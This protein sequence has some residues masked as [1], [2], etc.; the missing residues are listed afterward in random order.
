MRLTRRSSVRPLLP[1][2]L[3]FLAITCSDSKNPVEPSAPGSPGVTQFAPRSSASATLVGAGDIANCATT[4]SEET[5]R[6]LDA[7]PG[8]VF[9]V[10][11]NAYMHGSDQQFRECYQPT[12]GRHRNRTRPSPGN[13]DYMTAGGTPYFNYFGAEAGPHGLG[14]Y[15]YRLGDWQVFS[16]NS[17]VPADEGS[18][19]YQ[20][21]AAELSG[22][23]S[24]CSLA[25]WHHPVINDGAHG[26]SRQMRAIWKLLFDRGTDVVIAGHDHNYQRHPAYDGNLQRD[27]FRGIRSFIV[28]T[29]GAEEYEFPGVNARAEVRG[30]GWGVLKLT[31]YADSYDWEFVPVP[32]VTLRDF[33]HDTCH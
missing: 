6:L 31:L 11:D 24:R 4:G 32:G 20:W 33:G 8:T 27:A 1:A 28:G 5:A 19:Q 9:T 25:Y 21:L 29:G 13:H 18:A 7:I 2:M 10:G 17:N 3:A 14:Y 15:S 12:W 16:L 30:G 22:Q 23:S 26:D